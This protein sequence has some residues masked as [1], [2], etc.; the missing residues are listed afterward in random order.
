MGATIDARLRVRSRTRGFVRA[1][2]VIGVR[3]PDYDED[4]IRNE[5]LRQFPALLREYRM[6]AYILGRLNIPAT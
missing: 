4:N 1:E 2:D 3:N 5:T 6:G